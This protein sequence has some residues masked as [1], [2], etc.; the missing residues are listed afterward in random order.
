MNLLELAT[1]RYLAKFFW[2]S[3]PWQKLSNFALTA[4]GKLDISEKKRR[5]LAGPNLNFCHL[6][7]SDMLKNAF[8]LAQYHYSSYYLSEWFNE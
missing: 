3:Q 2:P 7:G 6:Y 8:C 1:P 4:S 5:I